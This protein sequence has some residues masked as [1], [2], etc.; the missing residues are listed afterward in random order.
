MQ[1]FLGEPSL[2]IKNGKILAQGLQAQATIT[3]KGAI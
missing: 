2:C 1:E 3:A